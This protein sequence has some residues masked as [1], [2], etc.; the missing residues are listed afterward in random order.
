MSSYRKILAPLDFSPAAEW[1]A[2]RAREVAEAHGAELTVI[3]VV[4]YIPPMDMAYDPLGYPAW[5]VAEEPILLE[6]AGEQFKRLREQVGLGE[7]RHELLMG[8]TKS[9]I[10]RYAEEQGMDLIVLGCHGRSGISRLLG[11]T[12]DSVLHSAPCDVLAVRI[13]E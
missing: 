11:S 10:V 1:V 12:A 4:E 5:D 6:R 13:R 9:E 8:V 3:H 7:V 2:R